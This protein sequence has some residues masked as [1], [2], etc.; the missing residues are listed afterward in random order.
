MRLARQV[1]WFSF[2]LGLK[3]ADPE[4]ETPI[5]WSPDANSWLIGKDPDARKDWRQK[6]RA[7]EENRVT[8]DEIVGWHHRFNGHE[9][10]QTLRDGE[11]QGGL[12]CCSP[13]GHEES[14]TTWW[15]NSNIY[16]TICKIDSQWELAVWCRELKLVL[17][18]NL[19][20]WDGVGAGR[21]APKEGDIC[22][23]MADSSWC[24]AGTNTI[25]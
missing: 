16:I 21:E 19:V 12:V 25:L 10:G 9:L 7:T 15:L 17:C 18:D 22:T 5:F 20:R 6:K 8:E 2:M 23:P 4:A 13:Q 24:M 14:A 3:Y 1:T 11:G